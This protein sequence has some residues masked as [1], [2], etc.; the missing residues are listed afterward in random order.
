M[1]SFASRT[2]GL[3]VL[4]QVEYFRNSLH[5]KIFLSLY[6]LSFL[7]GPSIFEQSININEDGGFFKPAINFSKL[8]MFVN[9]RYFMNVII[10]YIHLKVDSN[11]NWAIPL[12]FLV[13]TEL[14]NKKG[15]MNMVLLQPPSKPTTI[16]DIFLQTDKKSYKTRTSIQIEFRVCLR[17]RRISFFHKYKRGPAFCISRFA[18]ARAPSC[19]VSQGR[20]YHNKNALYPSYRGISTGP[21]RGSKS[22]KC[23]KATPP[24]WEY[25][26]TPSIRIIHEME[27]RVNY[28]GFRFG[29][30]YVNVG[31]GTGNCSVR[32][33]DS[34]YAAEF[35]GVRLFTCD[36]ADIQF[37]AYSEK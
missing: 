32:L 36:G 30:L 13:S 15:C 1:F 8:L 4:I 34:T 31:E 3:N 18:V 22:A 10:Y 6:L 23:A 19:G 11:W 17:S 7:Q 33:S 5:L 14:K 21:E 2:Y 28:L 24:K 25:G 16:R 37:V 26:R 9:G 27:N 29:R 12:A 35:Y 20:A